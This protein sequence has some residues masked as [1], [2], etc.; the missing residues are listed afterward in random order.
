M[1]AEPRLMTVTEFMKLPEQT[2]PTELIDG[3]VI[4][5]I[6]PTYEHN[7]IALRLVAELMPVAR[8]RK[9]GAWSVAPLVLFISTYNVYQPDAMFFT[10]EHIPDRKKLPLMEIPEIVVEVL[11]PSSRSRDR[12]RKR[13]AYADRGIAEYWI[14]DPEQSRIIVSLRNVEGAYIEHAMNDPVIPAGLFAGVELDL[15]WIFEQ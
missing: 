2:K 12:V 1:V 4:V 15:D 13:S 6:T 9:L 8:A 10:P 14:I 3:E 5:T 11:S 7:Q